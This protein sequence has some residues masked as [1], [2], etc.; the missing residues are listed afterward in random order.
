MSRITQR[1]QS[2]PIPL[3]GTSTDLSNNTLTGSKYDSSDGREFTLVQNGGTA[4]VAG[5]LIM[6]PKPVTNHQN[7]T[8]TVF[9]AYSANGNIPASVTATLGGTAI[10]A[11][12]YQGGYLIV[13]AGTGIGQTLK[14]QSNTAQTVTSGSVVVTLE[15]SPAVALDTSSKVSLR[16]NP[17]GSQFGTN[18]STNGVIITD[19]TAPTGQILGVTLYAV[20]ATATTGGTIPNGGVPNYGL[21][22]SRGLVSCLN[23][24]GTTVGAS[25]G[26]GL[27]PSSNTDGAVMT[28]V[29][30]T[31]TLVGFSTQTGVTTEA[32]QIVLTTL[33]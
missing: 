27:M 15:D 8:V 10:L 23:D 17:Y 25:G 31:G 33:P 16:L 29:V 20:A 7:L 26:L 30:A 19:H 5:T 6:G 2:G 24:S 13:N 9:T 1:G 32:R 4:L 18:A 3:F 12:A 11:N 14:I 22:Q 28:Y 21:I